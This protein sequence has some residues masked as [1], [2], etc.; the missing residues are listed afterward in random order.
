MENE[1]ACLKF[2]FNDTKPLLKTH[3]FYPPILCFT[4]QSVSRVRGIHHCNI[5]L[6]RPSCFNGAVI[7]IGSPGNRTQV[8]QIEGRNAN[9]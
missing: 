7:P 2:Q 3:S 5:V 6:R 1:I 9:H 4:R 8:F